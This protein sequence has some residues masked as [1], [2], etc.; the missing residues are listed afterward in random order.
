VLRA[1]MTINQA[2]PGYLDGISRSR[3]YRAR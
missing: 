3:V 1:Y 2:G